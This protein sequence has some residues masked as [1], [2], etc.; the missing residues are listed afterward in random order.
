MRWDMCRTGL[1]VDMVLQQAGKALPSISIEEAFQGLQ[2][3]V[4]MCREQRHSTS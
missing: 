1:I 4:C 3:L 2:D